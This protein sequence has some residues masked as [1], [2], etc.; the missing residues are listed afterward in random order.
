MKKSFGK[1]I[2]SLIPFKKEKQFKSF[3]IKKEAIFFIDINKI[4]PNPEQPRRKFDMEGIKA[5]SESILQY[6]VLQPLIVSKGLGEISSQGLSGEYQL[7]A[8]ERRLL[9]SKMAGLEQVP[10]II[11]ETDN[12]EK[13][14]ISLIENIQR[15]DLNPMERAI[16]FKKLEKEFK[17]SQKEIAKLAGK[18]RE[19]INN[20][21]R[22]LELPEEIKQAITQGKI[23]E[24]HA[25][26]ILMVKEDKKKNILLAQIIKNSFSVRQ[27]ESLAQK[28]NVWQP[29]KRRDSTK[30]QEIKEL[31]INIKKVFNQNFRIGK[32]GNK[33]KLTI[34]FNTKKEI[35]E[36]LKRLKNR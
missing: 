7:I 36:L 29:L 28:L 32:Y 6:G 12:K 27:A 30:D 19:A 18:S 17:L 11:R 1:G 2:E 13:L 14:E 9:A 4:K 35:K 16:A 22:L 5:L 24:G 26:A 23:K 33:L 3:K 15:Q 25:R 31:E 8:G 34:L 10:V 21:L 20:T